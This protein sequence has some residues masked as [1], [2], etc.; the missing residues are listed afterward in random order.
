MRKLPRLWGLHGLI[1]VAGS[2][3]L[4]EVCLRYWLPGLQGPPS[5]RRAAKVDSIRVDTRL[6]Y[7]M[8]PNGVLAVVEVGGQEV[9][10]RANSEGFIG[11]ERAHAKPPGTVRIMALGDSVVAGLYHIANPAELGGWPARLE[12]L[13]TERLHDGRS[14]EV[15]NAG[16]GGYTAWQ[17]ALRFETRGVPFAPDIVLVLVGWNDLAYSVRSDWRPFAHTYHFEPVPGQAPA[18]LGA[19][20]KHTLLA[21][22]YLARAAR[23]LRRRAKAAQPAPEPKSVPFNQAALDIYVNALEKLEETGGSHGARLALVLWPTP[24]GPHGSWDPETVVKLH[25]GAL[26]L[27]PANLRAWYDRYAEAQRDFVRRH[28]S[29]V[30]IDPGDHFAREARRGEPLF[31]DLAHLTPAG[32]AVLA[33]AVFESLVSRLGRPAPDTR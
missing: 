28:P 9:F 11:P 30:L 4:A 16:V 3:V 17:T 6:G 21:H 15:M 1:A 22:F 24:L 12:S 27:P 2:I 18:G 7:E 31:F 5:A 32:N 23:D 29:A 13:L 8:N 25:R 20:L 26:P 10:L 33:E 19:R 14:F